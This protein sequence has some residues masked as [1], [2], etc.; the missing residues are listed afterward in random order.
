MFCMPADTP[1]ETP[2]AGGDTPATPPAGGGPEG[3]PGGGPLLATPGGGDTPA[4]SPATPPAKRDYDRRNGGPQ[5]MKASAGMQNI[6]RTKT[7]IFP[8]LKDIGSVYRGLSE[9]QNSTYYEEEEKQLFKE[10]YEI[11]KLIDSLENKK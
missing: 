7:S 4:P 10:T 3:S 5:A 1:G 11:K 2:P 9:Q 6:G 8:G